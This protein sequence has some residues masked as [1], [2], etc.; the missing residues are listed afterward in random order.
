MHV[1]PI[2]QF[3]NVDA[4][5]LINVSARGANS[6]AARNE[7]GHWARGGGESSDHAYGHPCAQAQERPRY[8]SARREVVHGPDP[9]RTQTPAGLSRDVPA[10]GPPGQVPLVNAALERQGTRAG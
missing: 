8:G 10:N 9:V 7:D 3:T 6:G 5:D 1:D 2:R 4:I